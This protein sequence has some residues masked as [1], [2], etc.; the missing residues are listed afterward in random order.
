MRQDLEP[1]DD[2]EGR[3]LG[4]IATIGGVLFAI[5]PD[6]SMRECS[7]RYEG[8]QWLEQSSG[9]KAAVRQ[10]DVVEYA[11]LTIFVAG[12]GYMVAAWLFGW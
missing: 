9:L 5:R 4:C 1:V 6:G 11:A 7:T 3:S 12:A 10:P 2:A 8:V